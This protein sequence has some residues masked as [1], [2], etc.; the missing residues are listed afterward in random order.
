MAD[1]FWANSPTAT[2]SYPSDTQVTPNPQVDDFWAGTQQVSSPAGIP[3]FPVNGPM[4]TLPQTSEADK[5]WFSGDTMIQKAFDVINTPQQML[6][7]LL[8]KK[9]EEDLLDAA[10]RG[11][12]ENTTGNDVISQWTGTPQYAMSV[13]QKVLGGVV[14]FT[15][16][17]LMWIPA[18]KVAG[19]IGR[20][21]GPIGDF[22]SEGALSA[23][24]YFGKEDTFLNVMQKISR[25][26]YKSPGEKTWMDIMDLAGINRS[27]QVDVLKD[28]ATK[29]WD[30]ASQIG[31]QLGIKPEYAQSMIRNLS[32]QNVQNYLKAKGAMTDAERVQELMNLDPTQI[33]SPEQIKALQSRMGIPDV[34]PITYPETPVVTWNGNSVRATY[35][36]IDSTTGM[37]Y[38]HIDGYPDMVPE[39]E[40]Q[41][42][43]YTRGD[44]NGL[45]DPFPQS[46]N[47][48]INFARSYIKDSDF[49]KTIH[50]GVYGSTSEDGAAKY[51]ASYVNQHGADNV[52]LESLTYVPGK[53]PFYNANA[54]VGADGLAKAADGLLV[55]VLGQDGLDNLNSLIRKG[56]YDPSMMSEA[57][58]LKNGVTTIQ[59]SRRAL[60]DLLIKQLGEEKGMSVF[61]T[62]EKWGAEHSRDL[63][64]DVPVNIIKNNLANDLGAKMGYDSLIS[65]DEVAILG[66]FQDAYMRGAFPN[67]LKEASNA[68]AILGTFPV[69]IPKDIAQQ[70]F[71]YQRIYEDFFHRDWK[72]GTSPQKELEQ[73]FVFTM[74]TND[75][76][77]ALADAFNTGR[78]N[79]MT[80]D[81]LLKMPELQGLDV[82]GINAAFQKGITINGRL[83]KVDKLLEDNLAAVQAYRGMR[84]LQNE[85]NAQAILDGARQLGWREADHM[86]PPGTSQAQMKMFITK[87]EEGKLLEM[88]Y[89]QA[90]INAMK[91]EEAATILYPNEAVKAPGGFVGPQWA[92]TK[93]PQLTPGGAAPEGW[94]ELSIKDP[95]LSKF[96]D[97]LKGIKFAP[98]VADQME[99]Y[100]IMSHVPEAAQGFMKH[101]EDIRKVWAP[102]TLYSP[103]GGIATMTKNFVG[104][105]FNNA[106]AGVTKLRYYTDMLDIQRGVD[107]VY[108]IAG[109]EYSLAEIKNLM[110]SMGVW[111]GGYASAEHTA[112]VMKTFKESPILHTPVLGAYL[113]RMEHAYRLVEDNARGAHFM[114]I[115]D[116]GK[117]ALEARASMIGHLF[118]YVNGLTPMERKLRTFMPF[119]SWVRFNL[120]LQMKTL[121]LNPTNPAYRTLGELMSLVRDNQA[122][123]K[124]DEFDKSIL[125]DYV[126]QLGGIPY[127]MA[128]DGN[129]EY[130]LL[131]TWV[132]AM[133]LESLMSPKSAIRKAIGMV[134][135]YYKMPVEQLF[136]YDL[137]LQ[138]KIEDYPGETQKW[139]GMDVPRRLANMSKLFRFVTELNSMT[140]SAWGKELDSP[141]MDVWS[142]A[143]RTVFGG[144]TTKVNLNYQQALRQKEI[145]RV[146]GML[147]YEA[148]PANREAL[149]EYLQELVNQ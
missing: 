121:F 79:S 102:L 141:A 91:P 74:A 122:A 25:T 130:F 15:V 5:P 43:G 65:K 4:D 71:D 98:E 72:L 105:I 108:N 88:G 20:V 54:P 128:A 38:Y 120:P 123:R 119:L 89:S 117:T 69:K 131:G 113:K 49:A 11:A 83:V 94:R 126:K 118:D 145:Q 55:K 100:I 21:A 52:A 24:K 33:F 132:P 116:K 8:T 1:D 112:L 32:E 86:V 96:M 12:K 137:F 81:K 48:G 147:K 115:L 140:Q 22:I 127:R 39:N 136:N 14:Q 70:A 114:G 30:L 63:L 29:Q 111:G 31:E 40:L 34:V 125:P 76:R 57:E 50:G 106:I 13:G 104:N 93:Y 28:T 56:L 36:G 107:R 67:I 142:T 7:G 95:R 80:V 27:Y 82:A 133:E 9:P 90:E 75:G 134:A 85:T 135:P 103:F 62:A 46:Y 19:A 60:Q 97:N 37:K 58:A 139:V 148:N 78:W 35:G 99:K 92:E 42:I 66:S 3:S 16:D 41:L 26:A 87:P 64:N 101:L 68:Q 73:P 59:G 110:T 47:E 143:L 6:F 109:K 10:I 138:R 146:V 61:Q 17:P 124:A 84:T 44:P 77:K 45:S 144:G 18:E 129:P 51:Y 23:A 149:N 53:Q 2:T